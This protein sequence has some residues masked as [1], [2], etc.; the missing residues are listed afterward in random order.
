MR[1]LLVIALL[2]LIG[3]SGCATN[4]ATGTP[5]FMLV[6]QD[7]EVRAG[8]DMH[9]KVV[10]HF[11]HYTSDALQQYIDQVG[12]RVASHSPRPDTKYHFEILDTPEVNAFALPGGHIYITRGML[13][14]LDSEPQ[15]AAVLAHEIG[16]VVARHAARQASQGMVV[17]IVG[18][19]VSIYT[20]I[21][22]TGDMV[23]GLGNVAI[24]G[25]GRG[26]ELEADRLG[27]EY[28]A[29]SGYDPNAMIEVLTILKNQEEF[30]IATAQQEHRPPKVYHGVFS[31][32]PDTD[33]RLKEAVGAGA[34][35]KSAPVAPLADSAVFMHKLD[36]LVLV[37]D[38]NTR[39]KSQRYVDPDLG[40]AV[41]AP[42]MWKVTDHDAQ[43][44]DMQIGGG[45][46][47]VTLRAYD[48]D[49]SMT[50]HDLLTRK[51]GAEEV[52]KEIDL[53]HGTLQGYKTM[54]I[55]D[56]PFGHQRARLIVI[57]HEH[58]AFVFVGAARDAVDVEKYHLVAIDQAA[59][60]LHLLTPQ[61][62]A[63]AREKRLHIVVADANA[64]YAEL[65]K[66][67]AL[68]K[69]AAAQLRLLNGAYPDKEPQVGQ[70]IKVV[71]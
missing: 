66:H 45:S 40:L 18:A 68:D 25:Y 19:A 32:H 4:P 56:T 55:L 36:G 53:H 13:A 63:D 48:W 28:L 8:N 42:D 70:L 29:R 7:D 51:L 6:N 54:G 23:N 16:H 61:E 35:L 69:N 46:A 10:E 1:F 47:S 30:E 39:T 65:A 12:Q 64:N 44:I 52:E 20:G 3:L 2:A 15:L 11:G 62:S 37:S 27:A 14:Y 22:A 59:L 41:Q 71:Q 33:E 34:R 17:G 60:S 38:F 31:T 49:G 24:R 9:A 21:G 43:H 58:R 26:Y 67:C 50:A 5:D 57:L